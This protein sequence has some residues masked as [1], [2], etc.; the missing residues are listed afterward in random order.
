MKNI[1]SSTILNIGSIATFIAF[2][3]LYSAVYGGGTT[4]LCAGVALVIFSMAIPFI[5][6]KGS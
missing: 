5:A 4:V 1:S 2:P 6:R 3:L